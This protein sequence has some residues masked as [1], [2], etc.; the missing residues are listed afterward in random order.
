[1]L[2]T[3]ANGKLEKILFS[4]FLDQHKILLSFKYE[5]CL[6]FYKPNLVVGSL[7]EMVAMAPWLEK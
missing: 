6:C 3:L 2:N 5:N 1:M 7:D 4:T